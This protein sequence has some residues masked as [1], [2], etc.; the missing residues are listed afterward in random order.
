MAFLVPSQRFLIEMV[1]WMCDEKERA[2]QERGLLLALGPPSP[3]KAE[4][5]LRSSR[6]CGGCAK[7]TGRGMV[8][9]TLCN[10]RNEIIYYLM[11]M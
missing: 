6:C 4:P 7:E 1:S 5:S 2:R 3:P 9:Q 11:Y 8:G 10:W